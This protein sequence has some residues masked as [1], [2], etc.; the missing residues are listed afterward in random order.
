MST[1]TNGE[2]IANELRHALRG[3]AW[4]GPGLLEILSGVTAD[5][6]IQRPIPTAHNIWELVMHITS[7]SNIA[8]RRIEG[9]QPEPFD[10]EDWPLPGGFSAERWA[11]VVEAMSESHERLCR[12]VAAMDDEDLERNAPK[13]DRSIAFMLH[14]VAQHDSYH[15]GQIVLLRKVVNTH[16][17]RAA[18]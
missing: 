13:S 17:R 2:R 12:K 11:M 3:D 6:A 1:T 5:H 9:G 15:G 8:L 14:G 16:Q 7:W 10:G 4:H 18:V